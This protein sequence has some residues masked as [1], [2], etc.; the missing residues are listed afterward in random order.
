MKFVARKK[1]IAVKNIIM[2][3]F[4]Y[5]S[6]ICLI[7][8]MILAAY[9]GFYLHIWKYELFNKKESKF[10]HKVHSIR[11]ILFPLLV[12][13]LFIGD[14]TPI[15][16]WIGMLLLIID[17]ITLGIDAF[18]EKE[19]RKFMGGLP[20]W[21]YIIHLFS[22]SFHFAAI[23]LII[24]TK[25]SIENNTLIFTTLLHNSF[26]NE[27]IGFIAVNIIPGAILLAFIHVL[28]IVPR[29]RLFWNKYRLKIVCC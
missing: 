8:F 2:E 16:F 22:N 27:L 21:E 26:G 4:Y 5:L 29:G 11:A 3:I 6:A 28:L 24:G 19:S 1:A 17:S 9:D 10:E 25:I 15:F 23:I 20:K 18:S 13:L 12:W 14:L 7:L